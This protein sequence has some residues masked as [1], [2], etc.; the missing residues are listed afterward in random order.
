MLYKG[1]RQLVSSFQ[2]QGLSE[3]RHSS[4]SGISDRVLA[5]MV[6]SLALLDLVR[7]RSTL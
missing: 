5:V 2:V 1:S 4:S 3:A 6:F 7:L